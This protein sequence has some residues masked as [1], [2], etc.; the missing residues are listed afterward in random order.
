MLYP[1]PSR[2]KDFA[3]RLKGKVSI[4]TGGASGIGK[5][6]VLKFAQ[7]GAIVAV[8]DLNQETIDATVNEVKAAGGEA[9]GY[10]VNVTNKSQINDMVADVKARFGRIDVL[11]NNAGIVQDAQLTKMTDEQFDLVIDINLRGVYNCAK[12][13]VDTMV[14]Q[15]G[16][17]ILNASSVVGVY[18]NFGQ[19]NYAATKFGVIGFVKTW[20]K[21]LGK[22]GIRANAVCPGFVATPILKAMPE[23]VIQAMEDRVPMK[24][25]AQPEEIAN[26]YAFL[27]S[28]EASYING[29]AIEITG[30]LT[31]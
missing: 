14:A 24:R 1:N 3:M 15:G 22:K 21:E 26:L 7:E 5:A 12:A 28:D 25:M 11:V 2:F 19:T 13:V 17:V 16:G 6:T 23:K 10:I 27:A 31:Q 20:A 30:G 4:I 8:C 29:A 9:V 18:G